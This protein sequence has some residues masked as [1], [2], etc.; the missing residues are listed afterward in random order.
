MPVYMFPGL[1]AG[2]S[3]ELKRRM[4]GRSCFNFRQLDDRL[5]VELRQLT[6][7][8]FNRFKKEGAALA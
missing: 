1:L 8:S 5:M 3:P 4:Q 7:K 6:K 2:I